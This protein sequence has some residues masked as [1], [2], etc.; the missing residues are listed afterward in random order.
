VI[1]PITEDS[2]ARTPRARAARWAVLAIVVVTLGLAFGTATGRHQL[3]LSFTRLPAPYVAL[4]FPHDPPVAVAGNRI[5]VT[6][7]VADH[8][9]SGEVAVGPDLTSTTSADVVLPRDV[10]WA[11]VEVNLTG[12]SEAIH[13]AAPPDTGKQEGQ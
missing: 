9:G 1:V 12:R 11:R 10:G 8:E 13:Y 4:Y 5:T 3:A 6:F 7:T 2:T